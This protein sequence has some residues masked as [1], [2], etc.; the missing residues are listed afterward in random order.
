MIRL[1]C[2]DLDG[3]LLNSNKEITENTVISLN[4]A[5]KNGVFI[6]LSTGRVM[7]AVKPYLSFFDSN[8]PLIL[9]NGSI[10]VC[11]N[12]V[13]KERKIS[14]RSFLAFSK[15][16]KNTNES[17]IFWSNDK[18]YSN[19]D[20]E[21]TRKY[22]AS[23][24]TKKEVVTFD[25]L[26]KIKLDKIILISSKDKVLEYKRKAKF[27][28]KKYLSFFTSRDEYLEFVMRGVSKKSAMKE[29]C[30]FLKVKRK[31][32]LAIGDGENDLGMIKYSY[33]GVAMQNASDEIKKSAKYVTLSNDNEGVKKVIDAFVLKK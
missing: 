7:N 31:N 22:E 28:L 23:S 32:T 33:F 5:M 13:I 21:L 1:V 27:K 25:D 2:I 18:L 15:I 19:I 9:S 4:K 24:F 29:V 11:D 8:V 30:K 3:T 20:N 6:V 12:L 16:F 17:F 10:I 14:K 26:I